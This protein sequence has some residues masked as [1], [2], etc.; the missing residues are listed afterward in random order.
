MLQP[1]WMRWSSETW[2]ISPT[3]RADAAQCAGEVDP[4]EA[5]DDVDILRPS[6]LSGGVTARGAPA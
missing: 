3:G 1:L 6:T 2:M 5:Q 4:V